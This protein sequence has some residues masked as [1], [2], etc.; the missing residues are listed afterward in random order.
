MNRLKD[1]R[2]QANLTVKE[3]ARAVGRVPDWLFA[4]EAGKRLLDPIE[5]Q[6]VLTAITRIARF[7][8]RV[9][10]MRAKLTDDLRLPPLALRHHPVLPGERH[11][12]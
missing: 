5:E 10:E 4:V 12:S 6:A 9:A 11:A 3:V 8:E 2:V 1:A 7:N